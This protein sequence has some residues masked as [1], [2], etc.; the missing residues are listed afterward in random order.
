M[1]RII[2]H[3]RQRRRAFSTRSK[4]FR[5][6]AL[7]PEKSSVVKGRVLTTGDVDSGVD[8]E[9]CRTRILL[10]LLCASNAGRRPVFPVFHSAIT[11]IA[12]ET[13]Q[14]HEWPPITCPLVSF[15]LTG[16]KK[17]TR[18]EEAASISIKDSR[19]ARVHTHPN[20]KK[21]RALQMMLM[22]MPCMQLQHART[23]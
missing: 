6:A 16:D 14:G 19:V 1:K 2:I 23:R 18:K 5:T 11:I 10:L 20:A 13:C 7:F 8:K 15:R 9:C 3:F 22:A 12:G 4:E 21:R 17:R